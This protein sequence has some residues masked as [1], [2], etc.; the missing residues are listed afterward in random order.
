MC[1]RDRRGPGCGANSSVRPTS[2]ART[3]GWTGSISSSTIRSVR[4]FSVRTHSRA[5]TSGSSERCRLERA[6]QTLDP[7]VVALEWVLTE[8]R[9]T[10]RIVELDVDPV[11]YTH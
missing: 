8:N 6:D 2:R 10:L 7:L 9:L 11:S 1:I 3:T 4:R 5:T